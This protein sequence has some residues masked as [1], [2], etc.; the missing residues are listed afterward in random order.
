M[1]NE[2][3]RCPVIWDEYEAIRRTGAVQPHLHLM[4]A[5]DMGVCL[6]Y[7]IHRGLQVLAFSFCHRFLFAF[8]LFCCLVLLLRCI[9]GRWFL[10]APT[11]SNGRRLGCFIFTMSPPNVVDSSQPRY[12]SNGNKVPI[13]EAIEVELRK[14][15]KNPLKKQ[16]SW[17][18]WISKTTSWA[19]TTDGA[20]GKS[21]PVWESQ[22]QV[23]NGNSR[24]ETP[25]ETGNTA[26]PS[27][28]KHLHCDSFDDNWTRNFG[29]SQCR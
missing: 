10:L 5:R 9:A 2:Y 1:A 22:L 23:A 18:S 19:S 11:W 17:N 20:T 28:R 7:I 16:S 29:V 21:Q 15:D 8:F 24:A 13:W 4:S 6:L 25:L 27:S 26:V 14:D 12:D 3:G